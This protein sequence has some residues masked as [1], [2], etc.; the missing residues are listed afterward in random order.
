MGASPRTSVLNGNCQAHEV[1]NLFVAD[2]GPFVSQR[3]QERDLDHPGPGQADQRAHRRGTEKGE[4]MSEI[5][6]PRPPQDDRHARP[7]P[8]GSS[9]RPGRDRAG[10]RPRPRKAA[11]GKAY[12]PK[13]F[14][15]HEWATVRVLAD[16]VI[17]KDERSGSA[18]DALVPEFM[19]FMM[20]DPL[21][22]R[23]RA[24][25]A[26]DRDARRP[27]LARP[28]VRGP[29][30]QA[31]PRL[32]RGRA[33][34]RCSTTS[35]GP[36]KARPE[37][38][39][40]APS[41][42]TSA[43]SWLRASGRARWGWTT[44]TIWA[45]CSW[46]SG[47]AARRKCSRSWACPPTSPCEA[48]SRL[49][50]FLAASAAAAPPARTPVV[51]DTDIGGRHRRRLGARPRRGQRGLRPRGRH[52]HRRGHAGASAAGREAALRGRPGRRAGGGGAA[53]SGAGRS[54]RSSSSG[55]RTSLPASVPGRR[56]SSSST[57]RPQASGRGDADRG[58]P[59]AERGRR[60]AARAAAAAAGAAAGA[61]ERV[62]RGLAGEGRAGPEW[63]VLSAIADAQLVYAAG[64]PLTIVP[65]DATMLV[66]LPQDE[67]ELLR[68]ADAA[69]ERARELVPAVAREA[70][71]ADDAPRPARG[72]GGR[73][74]W[75]IFWLPPHGFPLVVDDKGFTSPRPRPAA[76][77]SRSGP[78]AEARRLHGPYLGRLL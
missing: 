48:L 23:A 8:R 3:P 77:P 22:D 53:D 72:L 74:P 28:R 12:A 10:R 42:P 38:S 4:P 57:E 37:M 41:S 47:R 27:G 58:R 70:G 1:K 44:S 61:D 62:H 2:A 68:E 39:Q 40:G 71:P 32:R 17:P 14:T 73:V 50:C 9:S 7:W 55:P 75:G 78:R 63:N 34:R 6:P 76:S 25:E 36:K 21:A 56:P 30:R 33:H 18:T 26:P 69:D 24:R 64:F 15:A 43:T 5:G 13:F 45:T 52:H 59:F 16:I 19:D 65:L 31:L 46:P 67:R 51:L 35:P 20:L 60:A 49:S 54:G 66:R 11:A 29:L